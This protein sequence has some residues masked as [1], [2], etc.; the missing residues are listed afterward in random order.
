M[1][2]F[3]PLTL[4]E[5]T[6]N[7][8]PINKENIIVGE[9]HAINLVQIILDQWTCASKSK[10]PGCRQFNA[11]FMV[12]GPQFWPL[13][14]GNVP[15]PQEHYP[16]RPQKEMIYLISSQ[17]ILQRTRLNSVG[18]RSILKRKGSK[19]QSHSTPRCKLDS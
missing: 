2:V 5:V 8:P 7:F 3:T 6:K 13:F 18:S 16:L 19:M 12:T 4:D 9:L 11:L 14:A 15:F 17:E 1:T 10:H